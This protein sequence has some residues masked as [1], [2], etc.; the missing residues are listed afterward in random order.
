M[1]GRIAKMERATY[2]SHGARG[3]EHVLNEIIAPD[4][5]VEARTPAE[6]VGLRAHSIRQRRHIGMAHNYILDRDSLASEV[7]MRIQRAE[8]NLL[9]CVTSWYASSYQ[10]P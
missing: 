3:S 9:T 7:L 6:V 5:E 10:T 4:G 2:S 8:I 1:W